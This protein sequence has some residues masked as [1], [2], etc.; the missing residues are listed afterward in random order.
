MNNINW[1]YEVGKLNNY[2]SSISFRD[3]NGNDINVE[4]GFSAWRKWI[5]DLRADKKVLY[6]AGNG[7]S[8]SIASHMA[9]DLAKNALVH[10]QVFSDLSLI[11]AMANDVGYDEV[12]AE[13]LRNRGNRQDML[14]AISS[15]GNS[16]NILN[17]AKV[18][19]SLDMS[20]VTLSGMKP[21][22]PLRSLGHLNMYLPTEGYGHT[23]TCHAAVLHYLMD[24][25]SVGEI[26]LDEGR[27]V[28]D[29]G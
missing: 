28:A 11:T 26:K 22:N 7:A 18:A 20:I 27:P 12:Y 9:A 13:P 16:N 5:V 15:S 14:V 10:T 3:V 25:V 2:L 29:R 23:E 4:D 21:D 8:A 19:R 17:A 6:L 1:S 24:L